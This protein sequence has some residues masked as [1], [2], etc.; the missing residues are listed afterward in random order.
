MGH[1]SGMNERIKSNRALL[2][3]SNPYK[4]FKD[5]SKPKSILKGKFELKKGKALDLDKSNRSNQKYL[6]KQRR[7]S[8]IFLLVSLIVGLVLT[9][10][11]LKFIF[12]SLSSLPTFQ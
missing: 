4:A 10:Y 8:R 11:F 9:F 3:R 2:K 6:Q 7:A 12:Q 1:A 5:Y